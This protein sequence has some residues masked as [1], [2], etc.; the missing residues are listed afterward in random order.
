MITFLNIQAI[1]CRCSPTP[2]T[3]HS[4]LYN[5]HRHMHINAS[6]TSSSIKLN[7]R[8]MVVVLPAKRR[9]TETENLTLNYVCAGRPTSVSQLSCCHCILVMLANA[10]FLA[11]YCKTRYSE[12]SKRLPPVAFWQ[13]WSE[14]NS[15]SAGAPPR[16]TLGSLSL[17]H[18]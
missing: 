6:I 13:L 16:T 10:K 2:V 15:F 12:Y 14:P 18:I 11:F 4:I 17:I 5:S 3:Q 1:N 7:V 9:K 8:L